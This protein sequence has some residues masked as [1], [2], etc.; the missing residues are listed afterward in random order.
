[1]E[2]LS[3]TIDH[4]EKGYREIAKQ[5]DYPLKERII[6]YVKKQLPPFLIFTEI[7]RKQ[8]ANTRALI[9]NLPQFQNAVFEVSEARY[10]TI[11][12]KVRRAII[13]SV[14]FILLTKFIFAFTVEATYDNIFLGKIAWD[15][16]IINVVAPPVL[17]VIASLFIRTPDRN[18]TK[19]IYDRLNNILF[20]DNPELDRKLVISLRPEN[21]HP[22]LNFTFTFLW[23]IAFILSFGLITF[24]LSKLHF[25][26][27]SQGVFIFF[28]A[29]ISFFT[30]R[31]SQT[32][33]S[34][35]IPYR[36]SFFVPIMDFLFM[37]VIRVGRRFSEGLVQI[38]ILIYLFD[39]LIETPFK[40]IFGFLEQWFFFLQTK[41][42][43]LG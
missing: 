9:A 3:K 23:W 11:S 1:M 19:R 22:I 38:N 15:S 17:M 7:I 27:A 12:S 24:I 33:H 4:F 25:S 30:Y 32:A 2:N 16:L 13:R 37:P 42:E 26:I 5:I 35:T 6:S 21:K 28:I 43:E 29:I 36:Q 34:Y 39:Y 31:I 20:V 18:N 8:R 14:I 41:R 10:K 40:E